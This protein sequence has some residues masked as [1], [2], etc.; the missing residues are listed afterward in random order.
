MQENN[1]SS[2]FCW[3]LNVPFGHSTFFFLNPDCLLNITTVFFVCFYSSFC[4]FTL[5]PLFHRS[6]FTALFQFLP[7]LSPTILFLFLLLHHPLSLCFF[8]HLFSA[9]ISSNFFSITC[10]L[11]F[12]H[13]PTLCSLFTSYNPVSP[14]CSC[15][16]L[17]WE[18]VVFLHRVWKL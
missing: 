4:S 18:S 11:C 1:F 15:S 3:I 13:L 8:S 9:I 16:T 7:F 2:P 5:F 12:Q 14:F 10:S 6:F 17:H